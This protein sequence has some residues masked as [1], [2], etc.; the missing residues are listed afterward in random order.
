MEEQP[1]EAGYLVPNPIRAGQRKV[2]QKVS[3]QS[4]RI[5]GT[6]LRFSGGLRMAWRMWWFENE[7]G[8]RQPL[9]G[10]VELEGTGYC[11]LAGQL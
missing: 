9:G 7:P 4:Q 11:L 10:E 6:T 5:H 2:A 3:Q 8:L 1:P